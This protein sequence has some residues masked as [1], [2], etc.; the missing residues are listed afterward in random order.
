M[1][2]ITPILFLLIS[3]QAMSQNKTYMLV[4]T[5]TSGKSEGVYVYEFNTGTGAIR[6]V[7]SAATSNPSYLAISPDQKFVYAVNEDATP[8]VGGKVSAY[9]F[10]RRNGHLTLVNQVRSMGDHPCYVAVDKT[11]KWVAVGNYSS[12]SLAV[13][14]AG[15]NGS[16]GAPVS[17]IKHSGNGP[18][19]DRQEKAHVHSTVF[20]PDNRYLVVSDLGTDK[21]TLYPFSQARGTLDSARSYTVDMPGG[22]GPRH[23]IFHPNGKW[24]YL[25]Q[26]LTGNVT[27]FDYAKGKLKPRQTI[28][29]LPT[30]FDKSFTSADIH[31][32]PDGQYLY[33]STRDEANTIAIFKINAKTG[34]LRQL[35]QQGTMGDTPRNFNLDPTGNFLLVANQNSDNIVVFRRNPKTGLLRDTGHR[36]QVGKPVCIKWVQ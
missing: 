11:G 35:S 26:E 20:T 5:Y 7:D 14:P 16:L 2:I 4:G 28:S 30:G 18:N 29:S 27:L 19:K 8:G 17:I 25:V 23:F 6:L 9:Q 12:G 3:M 13:F 31:I 24:G 21:V 15:K 33:T 36:V 32:S 10:N 1:K 22:T 34:Q